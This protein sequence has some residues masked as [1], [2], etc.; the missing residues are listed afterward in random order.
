MNDILNFDIFKS[1]SPVKIVFTTIELT[2]QIFVLNINRFS[3]ITQYVCPVVHAENYFCKNKIKFFPFLPNISSAVAS[4]LLLILKKMTG[5]SWEVNIGFGQHISISTLSMLLYVAFNVIVM[6][7]LFRFC[8]EQLRLDQLEQV[9]HK[10]QLLNVGEAMKNAPEVALTVNTKPVNVSQDIHMASNDNQAVV[11]IKAHDTTGLNSG[12]Q[13]ERDNSDSSSSEF[14]QK[15]RLQITSN[16][17]TDQISKKKAPQSK[18]QKAGVQLAAIGYD[19]WEDLENRARPKSQIGPVSDAND[20]A[21]KVTVIADNFA[22]E[23]FCGEMINIHIT[24]IIY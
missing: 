2:Q 9:T 15:I 12:E 16:G 13:E 4:L 18:A 21:A 14:A 24:Y 7:V 8:K 22:D 1:K 3:L 11:D 20:G 6:M 17:N 5:S 19:L 23:T 10:L